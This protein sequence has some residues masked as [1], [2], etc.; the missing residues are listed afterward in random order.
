MLRARCDKS[1]CRWRMQSHHQKH[2]ILYASS[3]K[4]RTQMFARVDMTGNSKIRYIR[5]RSQHADRITRIT[6]RR[7]QLATFFTWFL[8]REIRTNIKIE[9]RKLSI[10]TL[11]RKHLSL[12][13]KHQRLYVHV[14]DCMV[15]CV[16]DCYRINQG[17]YYEQLYNPSLYLLFPL[18][19]FMR[20]LHTIE[21]VEGPLFLNDLT[22]PELRNH[23]PTSLAAGFIDYILEMKLAQ[24]KTWRTGWS[25]LL[26]PRTKGKLSCAP[27]FGRLVRL[28]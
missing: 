26:L 18:H 21:T 17:Y 15:F 22:R 3:F 7:C 14:Q 5:G 12:Y 13:F 16:F 23:L 8:D 9:I 25:N 1:T 11:C 10:I 2:E 19:T 28:G 4:M 6:E 27:I 24:N 20:K